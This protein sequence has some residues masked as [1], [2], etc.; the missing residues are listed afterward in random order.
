MMTVLP[1]IIMGFSS[2]LL[3]IISLRQLLATFS[4]NELDIGITLAVWLSVVSMGSYAGY[5]I[6]LR[7]AFGVSFLAVAFLIQPTILFINLIRPLSSIE[8]GETIPFTATILF[9]VVSVLPLCLIIGLQFPMAVSYLKG[10]FS[11]TYTLEASGA[12]A[13]GILFTVLLSSRIDIFVL[14]IMISMLNIMIAFIILRKYALLP[15]FVIPLVFYFGTVR[16]N[17]AF[18]WKEAELVERVESRYGEITVL[19]IKDQ[20]NVY[21]SGK[22]Q[23]SYPDVQTEEMRS[24][25]PLTAHPAPTKILVIG[26]SPVIIREFLKYR[27]SAIDFVEIDPEMIAVSLRLL[28]DRDRDLIHDEKVTIATEDARKFVKDYGSPDYDMIILNLPEPATAN[29]NRFYTVDFFK[30]AA[31]VM[32]DNGILS[33]SLPTSS[34]YIS[35]KM[36]MANGSIYNSLKQ[37]F[38]MVAVSSEEYGYV[39]ASN[40]PI[41]TLPTTLNR[42]FSTRAPGTRHFQS[43]ILMDAFSPLKTN[44]VRGRLGKVTAENRDLRPVAYLYNL[45]Q[46]SEIHGGKVLSSLLGLKG[47]QIL[48]AVSAAFLLAAALLWKKKQVIYYSMFTTG[49]AVMAFSLLIILTFQSSFGYVYEMIGLLAALFMVGMALGSHIIKKREQPLK[50]L[51][52]SE[53]GAVIL[54]VTS[55][56][57]FMYEPLFYLISLLCGIIGGMQFVLANLAKKEAELAKGAGILY[58]VDLAGSFW[59]ALLTAIFFMPLLG[60]YASLSFLIFIKGISFILL[61]S[62][63]HENV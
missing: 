14:S 49:Y 16:I 32:K 20:F 61:L 51:R 38:K 7:H 39:F 24:H 55:P 36:Q 15:L 19:K 28:S 13:G 46:W 6:R 31:T 5:R 21:A 1:I 60:V 57:F 62:L 25:L 17:T 22:F 9:T 54:F 48:S 10:N 52:I 40:N 47:W 59:G 2:L 35:R 53:M 42:R 41:D 43:Y 37:V 3:Q 27:I 30:E 34:G 29:I 56:L 12:F 58:A 45:M 33:L 44:M 11:R 26:G 23:F 4:G 18:Q 8:F 50:W 63:G